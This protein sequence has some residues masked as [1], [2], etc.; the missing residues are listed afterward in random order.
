MRKPSAPRP[1]AHPLSRRVV[2]GGAA[3]TAVTTLALP[4]RLAA[5]PRQPGAGPKRR[6]ALVGTGIRGVSLWGRTLREE[7]GDV[8]EFVGLCDLNEGRLRLASEYIGTDCPTYPHVD[9]LLDPESGARP[10]VV[11]VTTIDDTHDEIIVKALAAGC[12]VITEKPLTTD[13][14][15]C[16][17]ILDAWQGSGRSL[18]VTFNY[19][20]SPHRQVM[21]QYLQDGRIGE[22]TS[23]DFHWYL[24]VYHGAAYFR[25]WHGKERRSGGLYVHKACHHFD[26]LNWWIESEPE[27][28]FAHAAQ[29]FYGSNGPF[30]STHCRPCPHKERCQFHWDITEDQAAMRLYV[31]NERYDGYLRDGCVFSEE[32][33]IFDKM[34]AAI[35]YRN[36]V[37]VSYSCTTYSPYE[38]YRIAFNGTR[39]RMEAWIFERQ[40][41]TAPDYDEIRITDNFGQTELIQVPHVAGGHGGG[42]T[43][44]QDRMFRDPGGADPLRQAAGLRD[45]A[46]A[47]LIGFAARRSAKSGEPVRIADLST[48]EP[49]IER[50]AAGGRG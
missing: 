12:D 4:R 41:W 35:R 1:S 29:D 46:M 20:Y 27:Q 8:V 13:E 32:N 30:R 26:L 7:Y 6:I 3:A 47:V 14:A 37:Q 38:G 17:R 34:S 25:R 33:D 31:E 36:G 48:L 40:P 50:P 43:R 18:V 42:D 49:Q 44:M 39:G 28:V 11:I 24:D 9:R 5:R 15:K 45:G 19:R 22:L 2:L 21:K 23:V 16:Q 10:E